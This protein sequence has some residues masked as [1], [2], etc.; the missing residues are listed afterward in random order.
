MP[1]YEYRCACCGQTFEK[2]LRMGSSD[3]PPCP[4]C[5]ATE[6]KRLISTIARTG[7]TSDCG[8]SGST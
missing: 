3:L 8:P 5:G 1:L 4:H 7:G 2:L 6:V